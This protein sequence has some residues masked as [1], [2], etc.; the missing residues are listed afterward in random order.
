MRQCEMGRIPQMKET[1]GEKADLFIDRRLEKMAKSLTSN[2]TIWRNLES[3]LEKLTSDKKEGSLV[4]SFLR[5]SYISNSQEFYVAYYE[6]DLFVE[7]EPDC[8]YFDMKRAFGGIEEDWHEIN[9][10][11]HQKFIRVLQEKKK[12][13]EDGTWSGFILLWK[14][15]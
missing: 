5:S 7:E 3:A 14:I 11:L 9:E 2:S 13:F 12:R 8:I 15:S 4:I 6:G 1:I 10:E